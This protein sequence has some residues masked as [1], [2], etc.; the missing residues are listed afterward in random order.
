MCRLFCHGGDSADHRHQ[1]DRRLTGLASHIG[2]VKV[3]RWAIVD[4]EVVGV[5]RRRGV[6]AR[7]TEEAVR[8][9]EEVE[10]GAAAPDLEEAGVEAEAIGTGMMTESF[11]GRGVGRE[12]EVRRRDGEV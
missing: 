8:R 3:L 2:I 6:V 11:T 12:A 7:V 1:F 4:L 5:D 10:A 9:T